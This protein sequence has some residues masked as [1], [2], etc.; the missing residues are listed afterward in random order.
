[1]TSSKY[2]DL[3]GI[4]KF[5]HWVNLPFEIVLD[6]SNVMTPKML[7]ASTTQNKEK[8]FLSIIFQEGLFCLTMKL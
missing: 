1:M 3:G 4:D 8:P 5:I 6:I 7:S 2:I